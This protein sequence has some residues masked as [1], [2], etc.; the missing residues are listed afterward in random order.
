M[1]KMQ[2]TVFNDQ[3]LLADGDASS[4]AKL[5]NHQRDNSGWVTS[6]QQVASRIKDDVAWVGDVLGEQ[7]E[8]VAWGERWRLIGSKELVG[9]SLGVN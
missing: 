6:D 8:T 1:I 3:L 7:L 5:V 9:T 2:V 4:T